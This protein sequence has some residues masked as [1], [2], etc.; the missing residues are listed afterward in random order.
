MTPFLPNSH[1]RP[2]PPFQESHANQYAI[3]DLLDCH[4]H[5]SSNRKEEEEE[6]SLKLAQGQPRV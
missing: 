1:L 4:I 2:N 6:Q 5:P 3:M